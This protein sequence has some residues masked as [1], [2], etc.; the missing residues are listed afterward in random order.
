MSGQRRRIADNP[1]G[2]PAENAPLERAGTV[3]QPT[4]AELFAAGLEQHQAGHLVEAE[5]HYRRILELAPDQADALHL[6]GGLAYQLARYGEAIELIDRAIEHRGADPSYHCT[7]GLVLQ[8]LGRLDEA[9][10]SYDYALVLNPHDTAALINRGLALAALGR[11]AEAVQSYDRALAIEPNIAEAWLNRSAALQRLGRPAAALQSFERA[12][13]VAHERF[14]EAVENYD[15]ELTGEP[16]SVVAWFNRGNALQGLGR[17]AEALESYDR[18]LALRPDHAEISISRGLTLQQLGRLADALESY[19]RA[20]ALKP[21]LA[22]A[23]INRGNILQQLGRFAEAME[24][25]DRALAVK[26][27]F[28]EALLN[29]GS[30]LQ[31]LGRFDEALESYD[32]ALALKPDYAAVL[33]NRGNTLQQLGHLAEAL[34]SYDQ[35]LAFKPDFAEALLN[36]GNILQQLGR[37]AE[38]LESYDRALAVNPY[39]S[40]ALL[41]RGN[42]LQQLGSPAE[43]LEGGDQPLALAPDDVTALRNRG[44]AVRFQGESNEA[45][46]SLG[47]AD[48]LE[49]AYALGRW[50]NIRQGR[51]DWGN[52]H[53]DEAKARD[54]IKISVS[55]LSPF[56][57]LALSSTPEE[58][59]ALA[60]QITAAVAVGISPMLPRAKPSG[61]EKIRLGYLSHDFREN[62][63]AILISGLIEQHDRRRFDIIGYSYGPDDHSAFRARL[64]R[65][66]DRFVDIHD[67]QDREAAELIRT[68]AVD[69]LIDLNGYTGDSRAAILAYRPAPIQV[70]YLGFTATM[71]ADFVDYIIVDRFVVPMDQQAFFSERLVHL[72]DCYQCNDDKREIAERTPSRAECG[73]PE[74][75]FVFCCFSNSYK[76]T[77][78]FFDI[79]MRLLAALPDSVL[80]LLDPWTKTADALAKANLAREA[81][82][83]GVMPERLIFAP[84]LPFYP[85]HLARHRP[86]DLFLD[87][88]PFNAHTTASD[89]LWAG[90]PLLTCAGNTFTGRVAGSLLRA[91][92]LGELVATSLEEYEAQA[93]RLARD[94][95]LLAQFRDRLARNRLTSPL[96]DTQ[97]FARNIE[98]AY[99]QMYEIWQA[100]RPPEAFSVGVGRAR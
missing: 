85:D 68:D 79:W 99:Q 74:A 98:T 20:L 81:A 8:G 6:L 80:W 87:T 29:R 21:D 95:G 33:L 2:S 37:F 100:G 25:Y 51:W 84:R 23:L 88:L 52:Y 31:Q 12:R 58:Q 13:A 93:L 15:R 30:I 17:W 59:L 42:A 44:I 19:D 96:F 54:A 48:A 38:A 75:G 65:A 71:G 56:A 11:F 28:V 92:G 41:N 9:L 73:L 77:P 16:D 64:E 36:R 49:P 10:G 90:L 50:F 4:A 45:V 89:A 66:F 34:E 62:A 67:M 55:R 53:E 76:I 70:N 3:T 94:A 40:E 27:D 60:R 91:V 69:I 26:P 72:P 47:R 18:A 82:A 86:A 1:G 43:E 83:R 14:A 22:E 7:R 39:F 97:R 46:V 5:T 57:L 32:R 78:A 35:A 63:L 24:T 61:A